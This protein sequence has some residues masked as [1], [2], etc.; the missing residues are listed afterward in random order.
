[1]DVTP[2]RA[3]GSF[4]IDGMCLWPTPA[5]AVRRAGPRA[6]R[7]VPGLETLILYL[8]KEAGGSIFSVILGADSVLSGSLIVMM[9]SMLKNDSLPRLFPSGH[10]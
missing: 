4:A 9:I 8:L 6:G 3:S 7:S 1:M 2:D 5:R 10:S